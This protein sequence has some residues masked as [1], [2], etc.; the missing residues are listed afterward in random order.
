MRDTLSQSEKRRKLS[1]SVW[2]SRTS[3][4]GIFFGRCGLSESIM[5]LLSS[6]DFVL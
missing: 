3:L 1:I 6:D 4:T 5:C 2:I